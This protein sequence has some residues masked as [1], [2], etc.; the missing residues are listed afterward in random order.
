MR[1]IEWD[2]EAEITV[3]AL[4]GPG[5]QRRVMESVPGLGRWCMV[6]G[7]DVPAKSGEI[8]ALSRNGNPDES[9]GSGPEGPGAGSI[10]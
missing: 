4:S 9:I 6:E 7:E 2:D 5:K 10:R 1:H 8:P 3:T